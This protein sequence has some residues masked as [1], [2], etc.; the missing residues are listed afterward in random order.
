[1][2]TTTIEP[3][4]TSSTKKKYFSQRRAKNYGYPIY[5]LW[6]HIFVLVLYILDIVCILPVVFKSNVVDV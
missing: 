4:N 3:L 1:M 2:K 5:V 6:V